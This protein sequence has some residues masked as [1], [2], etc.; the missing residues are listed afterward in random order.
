MTGT[1]GE[2]ER[3]VSRRQKERKAPTVVGGSRVPQ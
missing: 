1:K 3:D 2:D